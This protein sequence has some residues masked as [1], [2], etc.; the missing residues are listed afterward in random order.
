MLEWGCEVS[1]ET[2]HSWCESQP[3]DLGSLPAP[4]LVT[5]SLLVIFKSFEVK[6]ILCYSVIISQKWSAAF[7]ATRHGFFGLHG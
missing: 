3:W 4:D 1:S 5:E 7:V 6:N 2:R